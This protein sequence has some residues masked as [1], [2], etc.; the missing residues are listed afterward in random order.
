MSY[1][2]GVFGLVIRHYQIIYLYLS[3]VEEEEVCAT[4]SLFLARGECASQ[5]METWYLPKCC[6]F[7]RV[8]RSGDALPHIL[9]LF[10]QTVE[11]LHVVDDGSMRLPA[12]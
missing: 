3:R 9:V 4:L 1:I 10:P 5:D 7:S 11:F 6:L 12:G 8:S 2:T